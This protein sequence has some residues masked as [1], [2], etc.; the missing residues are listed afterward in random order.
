MPFGCVYWPGLPG[1]H[2]EILDL[3]VSQEG[4]Y[5]QVDQE[6][7]VAY[8]LEI[9]FPEMSEAGFNTRVI[10]EVVVVVDGGD[11]DVVRKCITNICNHS[12]ANQ[13]NYLNQI[14]VLKSVNVYP[15]RLPIFPYHLSFAHDADD[16]NWREYLVENSLYLIA[17]DTRG[18]GREFLENW[19]FEGLVLVDE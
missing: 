5:R 4:M 9:T 12:V 7:H 16:L 18:L 3:V 1:V 14:A 2:D 8:S 11:R 6:L 19:K 15:R 10:D 17:Q 13:R